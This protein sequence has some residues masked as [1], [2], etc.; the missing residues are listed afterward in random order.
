MY[1]FVFH[2]GINV[3][4]TNIHLYICILY[5]E[6]SNVYFNSKSDALPTELAGLGECYPFK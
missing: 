2:I 4:F 3:Y 5:F 6:A 1:C